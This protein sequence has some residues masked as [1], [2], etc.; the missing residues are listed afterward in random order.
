VATGGRRRARTAALQAL[1]EADTSSHTRTEALERTIT[2]QK[3]PEPAA[4]F[5]RDLI[6][7]VTEQQDV[8]DSAIARAAPAWPVEQL[9]AVDRNILRLAI[10]EIVGDNGTPVKAVIN[11]AVELAKSFGSDNS[12]KFIN[13]VLGTIE[14]QRSE[15]IASGK[16]RQGGE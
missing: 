6:R 9:S 16:P 15:L 3:M 7:G 14:R 5:A 11:E 10:Y 4:R 8:I 13:G 1:F 12:A 2:D